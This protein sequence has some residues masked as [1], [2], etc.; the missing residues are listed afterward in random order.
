MTRAAVNAG[1]SVAVAAPKP[2]VRKRL[3]RDIPS[4]DI[5]NCFSFPKLAP[6]VDANANWNY[7]VYLL[8]DL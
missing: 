7:S 1:T 2:A 6:P 3:L 5:C 8:T 4:P